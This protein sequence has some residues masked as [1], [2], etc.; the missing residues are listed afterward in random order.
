MSITKKIGKYINKTIGVGLAAL[1]LSQASMYIWI[2]KAEAFGLL[3]AVA[4]AAIAYDSVF[5]LAREQFDDAD[6]QYRQMEFAESQNGPKCENPVLNEMVDE[7]MN[8]MINDGFYVMDE[9]TLPFK[10]GVYENDEFNAFCTASS[11]IAIYTGFL[12]KT[13]NNRDELAGVIGH[14]M[15]HALRHHAAKGAANDAAMKTGL[16]LFNV[17]KNLDPAFIYALY[18]LNH[19]KNSVLPYEYDADSEGVYIMLSAGFNPGGAGAMTTI[20]RAMDY[21]ISG[22]EQSKDHPY[23]SR[24]IANYSKIMQ[25]ISMGHVKIENLVDVCIDGKKLLTAVPV[26]EYSAEEQ[27]WLIAGGLAKAFHD[28]RLYSQWW[29]VGGD[30]LNDSS[31]YVPLKNIIRAEN[32]YQE[33][34]TM[35]K[36]AYLSDS[37]TG[38]RDR[39]YSQE[40]KRIEKWKNENEKAVKNAKDSVK[41]R[42]RNARV[43]HANGDSKNALGESNRAIACDPNNL[44]SYAI[45]GMALAGMRN[46]DA[47]LEDTNKVLASKPDDENAL[48]GRA[49]INMQKGQYDDALVDCSRVIELNEKN[50][51]VHLLKSRCYTALGNTIEAESSQAVYDKLMPKKKVRLT[52]DDTDEEAEKEEQTIANN[53]VEN[54][55]NAEVQS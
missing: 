36:E 40:M 30:F 9:Y 12:E 31:A 44:T 8:Q 48:L 55:E 29:F 13:H 22:A 49:E 39:V 54:A 37:K 33:L 21:E 45:R 25:E 46:L 23:S 3:G 20:M 18:T 52:V 6:A 10:W 27:A 28:N 35:V 11:F 43:Y 53:N 14:E 16:R 2:P 51:Y 15:T 26:G 32:L 1:M 5:H 7:V 41:R 24:R 19:D 47:A 4:G 17:N 42:Q 38:N 50:P 34:E